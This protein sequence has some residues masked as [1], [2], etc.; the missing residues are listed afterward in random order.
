MKFNPKP[1]SRNLELGTL[2][3]VHCRA[4]G[5]PM[6]VVKWELENSPDLPNSIEDINGT[7]TF[8][9]VT[10]ENKGNY[11]CVASNSQGNISATIHIN[12]VVA[13]RYDNN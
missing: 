8:N 4:N 11:T 7:L 3:K 10:I 12:V 13:P 9:S 6:P 2:A 5:T 1:T